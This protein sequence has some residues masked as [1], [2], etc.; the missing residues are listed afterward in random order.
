MNLSEN[1]ALISAI[2]G[3]I[4]TILSLTSK[5]KAFW[6]KMWQ[7]RQA[8][9]NLPILV[10]KIHTKVIK[11]ESD[12]EEIKKEIRVNSGGSLKDSVTILVNE[13]MIE[14]QEANYPAFRT[15]SHGLNVFTNQAYRQL[16]NANEED[17]EGQG[18]R[19]FIYNEE[20]GSN[21]YDRWTDAANT[22]SIFIAPL[23]FRNKQSQYVGE[24]MVRIRP[25]GPYFNVQHTRDHLWSGD[26]VPHDEVAKNIAEEYKWKKVW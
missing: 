24:W 9:S 10:E 8:K 3:L 18:W 21:F 23:K 4:L 12:Q 16:L 25:L 15:T 6:K 11:I 17:L 7:K 20:Q 26:M 13:R 14:L 22:R 19:S 2:C 1:I 5:G